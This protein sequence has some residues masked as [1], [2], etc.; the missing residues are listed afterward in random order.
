MGF[1]AQGLSHR[2]L[3]DRGQ[4]APQARKKGQKRP[5]VLARR[6]DIDAPRR[7]F[8]MPVCQRS[9]RAAASPPCEC[10]D[11]ESGAGRNHGNDAQLFSN[12]APLPD[13]DALGNVVNPTTDT[14][15]ARHDRCFRSGNPRLEIPVE[16]RR[17]QFGMR[18]VA[19][20]IRLSHGDD[21]TINSRRRPDPSTNVPRNGAT[22]RSVCRRASRRRRPPRRSPAG[23][24]G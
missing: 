20:M 4:H 17:R 8:R 3:H 12:E 9:S 11:G 1:F 5:A 2:V 24:P 22:T 16:N 23:S 14:T 10:C 19:R 6:W 7:S 13:A 21:G 15:V 18:V